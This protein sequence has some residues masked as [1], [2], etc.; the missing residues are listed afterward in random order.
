MS[1]LPQI[2]DR[3]VRAGRWRYRRRGQWLTAMAG[4]MLLAL[5]GVSPA[6]DDAAIQS[7]ESFILDS[8]FVRHEDRTVAN[9]VRLTKIKN[10]DQ[11]DFASEEV[12]SALGKYPASL[13]AK[14]VGTIYL[15]YYLEVYEK[16]DW[17]PMQGFYRSANQEV[18]LAYNG[19]W[20]HMEQVFHHELAHGIHNSY[21]TLFDEKAW[22]AVNPKAFAY[23]RSVSILRHPADEQLLQRGF[24]DTYCAYALAE[25]VAVYA[26]FMFGNTG[27]FLQQTA[28]YERVRAK[29]AL[30]LDFYRQ[31][32]PVL[33]AD[34]LQFL[35]KRAKP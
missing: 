3:G 6:A 32:D 29:A 18:Y 31:V 14:T 19:E 11:A 8:S 25:D 28:T 26:E 34:Y 33:S 15:G 9:L 16:G 10:E 13:I 7:A 24:L 23:E 4:A 1:I 17:K 12:R 21:R 22:R 5:A 35:A 2:G 30:L 20:G 27:W